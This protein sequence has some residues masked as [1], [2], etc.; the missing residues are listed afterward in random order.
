MRRWHPRRLAI[1]LFHVTGVF[2]WLSSMILANF[3]ANLRG[4]VLSFG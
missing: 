3:N 1:P 4:A 2:L